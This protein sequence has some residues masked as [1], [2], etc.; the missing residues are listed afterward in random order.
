VCTDDCTHRF[1]GKE[2][3]IGYK[4]VGWKWVCWDG[5]IRFA[6]MSPCALRARIFINFL[7]LAERYLSYFE[8]YE[9]KRI[10]NGKL[11]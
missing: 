4:V 2:W 8:K 7:S 11:V 10:P 5:E 1:P 3:E 6:R 9:D